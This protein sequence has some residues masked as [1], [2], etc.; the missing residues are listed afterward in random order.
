MESNKNQEINSHKEKI[1]KNPILPTEEEEKNIMKKFNDYL[2]LLND[3]KTN[4]REISNIIIISLKFFFHS[5]Y[6]MFK[7]QKK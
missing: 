3:N 1:G 2:F 6:K 5:F 7:Q 4:I